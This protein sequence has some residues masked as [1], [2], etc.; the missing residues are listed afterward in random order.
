M[1]IFYAFCG[2]ITNE[3]SNLWFT[4]AT[5]GKLRVYLE[6][7][8]MADNVQK[9]VKQNPFGQR[10][11]TKSSATWTYY[12]KVVSKYSYTQEEDGRNSHA[13]RQWWGSLNDLINVFPIWVFSQMESFNG[14]ASRC[15]HNCWKIPEWF[16]WRF[17]YSCSDNQSSSASIWESYVCCSRCYSFW[18][19]TWDEQ[20]PFL[21]QWIIH[22]LASIWHDNFKMCVAH[23]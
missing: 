12:S 11:I 19:W 14:N 21:Y 7:L 6:G 15:S 3:F 17:I 16:W 20:T 18:L 2:M 22:F 23:S 8:A 13:C 5:G 4:L 10:A 1:C 9:Y